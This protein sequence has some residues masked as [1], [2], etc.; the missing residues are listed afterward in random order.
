M[1]MYSLHS[2]S[3]LLS[4]RRRTLSLSLADVAARCG[5]TLDMVDRLEQATFIPSPSQAFR[6]ALVLG[7]DPV[8]L[9]GRAVEELLLHPAY[10]VEHVGL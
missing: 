5:L 10:L 7:I 2:F 9:G 1:S 6:L 3:D 4:A 8:E